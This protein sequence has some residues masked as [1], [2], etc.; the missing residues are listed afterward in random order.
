MVDLVIS[1][2]DQFIW[3]H[4]KVYRSKRDSRTECNAL[5]CAYAYIQL[6]HDHDWME[7]CMSIT[8]GTV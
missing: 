4:L 5:R 8:V 6:V 2:A 3:L 7:L 1:V